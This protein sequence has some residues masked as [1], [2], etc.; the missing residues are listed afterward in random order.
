MIC[1][2]L[3]ANIPSLAVFDNLRY[4]EAAAKLQPPS[5]AEAQALTM[6]PIQ[7][8]LLQLSAQ[9]AR[10]HGEWGN[11]YTQGQRADANRDVQYSP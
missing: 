11:T 10:G 3:K 8:N 5:N 2:Y 4:V 6:R 1:T 9:S 7:T